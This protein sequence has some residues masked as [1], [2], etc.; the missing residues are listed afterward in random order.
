MG[1][2]VEEHLQFFP[3][4]SFVERFKETVSLVVFFLLFLGALYNLGQ[5][6][7]GVMTSRLLA[8]DR[9]RK[10][11]KYCHAINNQTETAATGMPTRI[12]TCSVRV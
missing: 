4:P 9:N 7:G 11:H 6:Q 10:K 3:T 2:G 8:V 12:G 5:T 1:A